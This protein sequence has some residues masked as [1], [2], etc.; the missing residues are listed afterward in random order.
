MLYDLFAPQTNS[1][2]V[3]GYTTVFAFDENNK[4][5]TTNRISPEEYQKYLMT[6]KM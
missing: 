6:A 5:I 2:P 4:L 3:N 1:T